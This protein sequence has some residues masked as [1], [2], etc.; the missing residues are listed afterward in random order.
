M[1][2]LAGMGFH[3]FVTTLTKTPVRVPPGDPAGGGVERALPALC[4]PVVSSAG[5]LPAALSAG[6]LPR[7]AGENQ[8][9]QLGP[10]PP[11]GG[12]QPLQGPRG[13]S[14]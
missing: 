3:T 13:R 9:H 4:H 1:L 6:P 14:H 11:A 5:Q 10:A 2:F 7:H 8:L 12:L